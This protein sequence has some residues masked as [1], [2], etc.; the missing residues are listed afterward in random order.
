[1]NS[2]LHERARM[3]VA[4]S[5]PEGLAA[6]EQ[7]WLATHLESCPACREFAENTSEAIASLRMV[8]VTA[9]ARLISATQLRVRQRA[10]ELQNRQER[11]W[12]VA[13]CCAAVTV[14]AAVTTFF[15]WSGF[16]WLGA[17]ARLDPPVW[18]VSFV[19]FSLMP[20]LVTGLLLL[21]RGTHLAEGRSSR[22][23]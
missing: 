16:A 14:C 13:V 21:A 15:L 11:M 17:W 23:H 12:I 19:A 8:S 10:L 18:A 3:L 20:A 6:E 7:S 9:G 22:Q 4:L 1:M 5:G 2:D